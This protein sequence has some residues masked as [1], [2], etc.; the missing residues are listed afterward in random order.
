VGCCGRVLLVGVAGGCGGLVLEAGGGALWMRVNTFGACWLTK[1]V[2][3][4]RDVKATPTCR[5]IRL[6]IQNADRG[7]LLG[8]P[9]ALRALAISS[10]PTASAAP[11]SASTAWRDWLSGAARGVPAV[12]WGRSIHLV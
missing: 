3:G 1:Q 5:I 6:A 4:A 11:C 9:S 8:T 12:D 2:E 7:S 10:D